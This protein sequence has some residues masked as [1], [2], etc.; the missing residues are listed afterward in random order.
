[1]TNVVGIR[2]KPATKVYFFG[3]N[4]I[5]DLCEGEYVLV[6]T[7][8]GREAGI[9]AQ[10]P[11]EIAD[12]EVVG[13]LKNVVGRLTTTDILRMLAYRAKEGEVLE[14]CRAKV[15]EHGLPMKLVRAEYNYDGSRLL[16]YFTSEKR[17]D[18]RELVRELAKT[19]RTRIELR[20]IG[21]RDEA[22]L[23]GGLGCCGRIQCCSSWL[24]EFH[25][26]SIK[27]AKQQNLPLSPMEISG[28]CGRLLCCLSYEN[29]FYCEARKALPKKGEMV[30]TAQGRGKVTEVNVIKNS[31]SVLLE[32]DVTIEVP[33]ES[34]QKAVEESKPTKPAKPRRPRSRRKPKAD[35]SE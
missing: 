4:G 27:M 21:V 15:K 9:V 17:V 35:R 11:H 2:F 23:L 33:A 31:V 30:T 22:K 13:Q 34:L 16:F 28:V 3:P 6:E 24:H 29:E 5:E 26:V 10:P 1:M 32:S 8:R 12:E 25:P 20:Q 7:A 19:F 14:K 18:F